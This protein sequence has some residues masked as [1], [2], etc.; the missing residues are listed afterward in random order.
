M[1]AILLAINALL[2]F[3]AYTFI[4]VLGL[5]CSLACVIT[6]TRYIHQEDTVDH[7]YPDFER[8]CLI[9]SHISNG[10]VFLSG[11][12]SGLE[13]DPAVELF[14]SFVTNNKM[15]L[16]FGDREI[17][18]N[19][20]SIDST[21]FKIFPYRIIAGS[22]K[23][24][25]PKDVIITRSFCEKTFGGVDPIGKTFTNVLGKKF[26]IIG[27][28]DEQ[29]TKTSW[30]PEIFMSDDLDE[31]LLF[32]PQ[33]A[34]LM[35]SGTD[36]VQL[37]KKYRKEQPRDEWS[38]Y[39]TKYYQYL[40]LKDF[41]YTT[42]HKNEGEIYRH[43][44]KDYI[45]VLW[46]VAFLV[47]IIGILNFTN[48]YTVIMSK[49]SREFGVKKVYGA[50]R[51]EIF[52][53]IYVENVL[54][55]G[56][57]LILC[58]TIIELT[59]LFFFNEM[60]IPTD[61]DRTFDLKLSAFSLFIL[62]LLTTLYPYFKYTHSNP[63][64]SMRELASSRF[65]TRSRMVF[66]G[67]Q[68]VITICMIVVSLFFVR[69]LEYMLHSDLGFRSHDVITCR[70][71]VGK[72]GNYK[73]EVED[74][75]EEGKKQMT[76]KALVDKR[77]GES[78]LFEHWS[79]DGGMIFNTFKPSRFALNQAENGFQ[80]VF[81]GFMSRRGMELFELQ[82]VEG[83]L[84]NDSIDEVLGHN[85]FK[86]IINETAKKKFGI[87]NIAIDKLLPEDKHFSSTDVPNEYNP[88]CEIVG[89]VKDFSVKHLSQHTM[90]IAIYYS[91][92]K[93]GMGLFNLTVSYKH[94]DRARVIDFLRNL[95]EEAT[96][97][98]DFEYTLIEDKLA[99]MYQE[100]R[101]VVN[102]YSLFAGVAIFISSLGLLSISLFD[103]RQRYREIGLRKVNGAQA[104]DIYPLLIKKYS[105]VMGISVLFSIPI[106][107]GAI[108]LYLRDFA[109]K[110]PVTV[111]L[112]VIAV[113]VTAI[114]SFL[115]IIWQIF[116]AANVNPADV[117]KYE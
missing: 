117:I 85:S 79:R 21:F 94:E 89:V 25:R 86:V 74:L 72:F 71:Y 62:P 11:Y 41:Y 111:D 87:K 97:R 24:N 18:C 116:K 78:A 91:D 14:T 102:I 99:E 50:G 109:H 83:R 113:A 30:M 19:V 38:T 16:Q 67:F 46:V 59:K 112:F 106:S 63:V 76:S 22:G 4:N 43:G 13:N 1:K 44:N 12:K 27:V 90:P 23:I 7:C 32:N 100:D 65:S 69:Q 114:L 49:R 98:T 29:D 39:Q 5:A 80:P 52:I 8:I 84:W 9:E 82:L 33:Y 110:A 17:A 101:L 56:G 93:L 107:W 96:G 51:K 60:Y 81:Q 47:G 48:I 3:K 42:N 115:T 10:E 37:N 77:M 58:W 103:I 45:Q 35:A 108:S 36:I 64:S 75:K 66:L 20:F 26:T 6:I 73:I 53:Q 31:F 61:S 54:L 2:K 105:F 57:A 28:V 34:L 40:P 55:A 70:M 92:A 15:P 88:P 95:Y 68:Y 104:Q